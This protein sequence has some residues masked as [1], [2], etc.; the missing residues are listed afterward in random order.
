VKLL[1]V[2]HASA[3]DRARWSGDDR[4]RPLDSRGRRQ[5]EALV[6]LLE[7]FPVAH[8]LSSPY[9]R[10]VE[11]LEP[12]AKA[13]GLAVVAREELAEGMGLGEFRTVAAELEAP[14]ALCVH[15]DLLDELV[16]PGQPRKKGSVWVVERSGGELRP[17]RYVPPP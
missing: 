6:P 17:E 1:V 13:R 15:G 9:V 10:C 3:G 12:L 4:L 14:A 7:P 11:T 5:A 8:V 16:G 2:R